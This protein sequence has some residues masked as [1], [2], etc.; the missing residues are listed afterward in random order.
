MRSTF[1]GLE[2]ARTALHVQQKQLDITNHNIANVNTEGYSRQRGTTK[3]IPSYYGDVGRG[4]AMQ[5]IKQIRDSFLDMQLRNEVKS[6][7]EWE[8][9][10]DFL[11]NIEAIY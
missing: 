2:I 5:E 6:L 8:T 1:Y 7:G 3:A 9:K 10:A 11:S 4:V